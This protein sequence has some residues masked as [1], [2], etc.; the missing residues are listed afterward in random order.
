[1]RERLESSGCKSLPR[2]TKAKLAPSRH[3]DHQRCD[4]AYKDLEV[5]LL[6]AKLDTLVRAHQR[7]AKRE[8]VL[9]ITFTDDSWAVVSLPVLTSQEQPTKFLSPNATHVRLDC[10]RV[11]Q[12]IK[13]VVCWSAHLSCFWVGGKTRPTDRFGHADI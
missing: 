7:R 3:P 5:L 11:S 1:M 4:T 13:S 2:I 9:A 6:A 10:T 12:K 8:P